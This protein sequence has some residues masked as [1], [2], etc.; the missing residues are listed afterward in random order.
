MA[1]QV[2]FISKTLFQMPFFQFLGCG[3]RVQIPILI[4]VQKRKH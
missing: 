3:I 4:G 2:T 1:I